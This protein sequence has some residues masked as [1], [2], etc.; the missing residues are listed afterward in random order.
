MLKWIGERIS[1]GAIRKAPRHLL[2]GLADV[3]SKPPKKII[4]AWKNMP[5][6][7]QERII[8]LLRTTADLYIKYG[9]KA[10]K[11]KIEF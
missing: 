8:N 5:E 10:A 7:D 2:E 9:S 6:E 1:A 3:I 4:S 11:G